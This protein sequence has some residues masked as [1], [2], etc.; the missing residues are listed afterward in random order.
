MK[1]AGQYSQEAKLL[2]YLFL[3]REDEWRISLP[4]SWTDEATT[5]LD[6][7]EEFGTDTLN[8]RENKSTPFGN[9]DF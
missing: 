5:G 9:L 6:A 4:D 7:L 2:A 3:R 8:E 1:S